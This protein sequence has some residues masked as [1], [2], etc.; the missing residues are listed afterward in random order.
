M[1]P[2][3]LQVVCVKWGTKYDASYV[4]KLASSVRRHLSVPHD[5][6]CFTDDASSLDP[7]ITARPL[8]DAV[9]FHGWW[10]KAVLFSSEAGLP[11][12]ARVLYLDLDTVVTG[13]LDELAAY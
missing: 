2:A 13:C 3:P 11:L 6:T 9:P 1:P 4:N 7:G 12:G 8:P 10:F 5:F